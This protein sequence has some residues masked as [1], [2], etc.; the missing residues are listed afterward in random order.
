MKQFAFVDKNRKKAENSK[1][2][3]ENNKNGV[4]TKR[5]DYVIVDWKDE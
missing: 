3:K 4:K 2:F 1:K 5:L